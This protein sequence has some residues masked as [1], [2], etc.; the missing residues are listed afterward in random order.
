MGT[1]IYKGSSLS[2][3]VKKVLQMFDAVEQEM[4]LSNA[5]EGIDSSADKKIQAEVDKEMS[6]L[7]QH[8]LNKDD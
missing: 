6:K 2:E 7:P 8:L 4:D 1:L 3:G 5:S